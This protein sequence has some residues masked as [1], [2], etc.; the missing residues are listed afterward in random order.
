M[1]YYNLM[2]PAERTTVI[3]ILTPHFRNEAVWRMIQDA[4]EVSSTKNLASYLEKSLGK[5]L[6]EEDWSPKSVSKLLNLQ[7]TDSDF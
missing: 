3:E 2:K 7:A 6:L 1:Q 4:K 5:M